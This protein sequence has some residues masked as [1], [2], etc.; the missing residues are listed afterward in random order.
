MT[1]QRLAEVTEMAMAAA[2]TATV[3]ALEYA[4]P[5]LKADPRAIVLAAGRARRE[6]TPRSRP[7]R[8]QS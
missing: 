6:M 5:E 2:A 4:A 3:A 1:W 7:I 8:I